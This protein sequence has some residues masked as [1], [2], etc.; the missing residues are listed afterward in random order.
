MKEF[1]H[2]SRVYYDSTDAG[3]VLYHSEY[4]NFMEHARIELLCHLGLNPANMHNNGM[5]LA[6]KS[7]KID[8]KK[9]VRLFDE[10]GVSCR[11]KQLGRAS[12]VVEQKIFNKSNTDLLYAMA[13]V[14][15]V[16]VNTEIKPIALPQELVRAVK[17][18]YCCGS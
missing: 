18:V 14:S 7:I 15:L 17:E 6:V 2:Y 5:M 9:P 10:I 13:D 11:V 12:L 4:I 16:C 8:Y 3:G 1:I